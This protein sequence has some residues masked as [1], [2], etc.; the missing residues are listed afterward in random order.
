[1]TPDET[2]KALRQL[3]ADAL[4]LHVETMRLHATPQG[5]SHQAERVRYW[6]AVAAGVLVGAAISFGMLR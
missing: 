4:A 2:R 6:S 5:T 1:M 3:Q